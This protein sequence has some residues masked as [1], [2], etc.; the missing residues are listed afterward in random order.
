VCAAI[1][2]LL[3]AVLAIAG[4]I[5]QNKNATDANRAQHEVA[6][7]A[8]VRERV[9]EKAGKQLERVQM[10]NAEFILPAAVAANRFLAAFSRTVLDCGLEAYIATYT[11]QWISP[12]T[13]PHVSVFTFD[14]PAMTKA[15][16]ANPFT[17]TLSPEDLA[18]LAA[19]PVKRARWAES[20]THGL[21]PPLRELVPIIQTKV[22][23]QMM[24]GGGG[25]GRV[26]VPT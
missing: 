14:N 15:T 4:Y 17:F 10:Q 6:Q 9:E 16:A 19:D 22:R 2:L 8:A 26:C 13:Q 3:T 23:L 25:R 11:M 24:W 20:V 18:R 5:V 7:E 21:L 12:P 1:A